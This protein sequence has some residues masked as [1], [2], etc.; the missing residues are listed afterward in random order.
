MRSRL[1]AF[2]ETLHRHPKTTA[3]APESRP[4]SNIINPARPPKK[5]PGAGPRAYR[6]CN[7]G[8][9]NRGSAPGK[10]SPVGPPRDRPVPVHK[11]RTTYQLDSPPNVK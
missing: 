10:V 2:T 5:F 4:S 11:D 6:I 9:E 7:T 1:P 3:A 8:Y